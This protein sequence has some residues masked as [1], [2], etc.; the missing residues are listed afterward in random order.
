M[1][2][3]TAV[4]VGCILFVIYVLLNLTY[5]L[6]N[7]NSTRRVRG[8]NPSERADSVPP[9][10][11][12]FEHLDTFK[13]VRLE[14]VLEPAKEAGTAE[15]TNKPY[16]RWTPVAVV[17]SLRRYKD[18]RLRV[19]PSLI[20]NGGSVTLEWR[21]MPDPTQRTVNSDWIAL[22]CPSSAPSNQFIDFW[23]V[24]NLITYYPSSRG[25][26]NFVLFNVRTDCEFRYFTNDTYVELVAVSNKVNFIDGAEAPLH[27]HLSLMGDASEMRVQWT[28]GVQYVP[29][30]K[31]GLC[32][33]GE[34][35][36]TARGVSRT[37]AASD[38]CGPPA[39][40]SHHFVHPGYM[41]DVVLTALEPNTRYCYRYGSPGFKYS[42]EQSFVSAIKP[43]S[44]TPFKFVAYGDMDTSLPPGSFTTA[45][46]VRKDVIE[47]G[48]TIVLHV[49]DL[50][51]AVGLGYRWDEWMTLIEPYSTLAPYMIAI[52]NHEQE[53]IVGGEKD[54]SH[55]PGNGFHPKWGNYGHDSGGECGVPVY[56]RFHMPDRNGN[57]PWWYSYEYGL[58]HF[59]MIST[60][61]N[62][63]RGSPQYTWLVNDLKLVNR[64]RT[65]WLIVNL[66][67]AMYSSEKY[68][69]DNQTGQHIRQE[70]EPLFHEHQVDIVIAGHYHSYERSCRVYQEHCVDDGTVHVTVG[71]AGFF[72]DSAKLGDSRWKEHYEAEFGYGRATVVNRTALLWEYVRNRDKK[73]TDHV[74]L[75]H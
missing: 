13:K 71:A 9:N 56:N 6:I 57:Q 51:Y 70:L 7:S 37:Y 17:D 72:L 8:L 67:R 52:G 47:N 21:N 14:Y 73:V 15:I 62:F 63:T 23:R 33:K 10:R 19:T 60:E 1:G 43:G 2:L 31:Y 40:L 36:R 28:T 53:H 11:P 75:Y 27:G 12:L 3:K 35:D 68:P 48:V 5:S 25:R 46:L 22:F 32:D 4:R 18:A 30:V 65:P 41:H 61:N 54:P 49:G 16:W 74:W 64:L 26:A 34:L 24:D 50:S 29:T 38:M 66:H 55:H 69:A 59:T 42:E 20:D 58:A 39:N 45:A 44:D